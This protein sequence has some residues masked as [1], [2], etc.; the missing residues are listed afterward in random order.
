MFKHLT[1]YCLRT[2]GLICSHFT[3]KYIM[4]LSGIYFFK[5]CFFHVL[6]FIHLKDYEYFSISYENLIGV[7]EPFR[8]RRVCVYTSH[9]QRELIWCFDLQYIGMFTY[10]F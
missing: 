7:L 9:T 5:L 8:L 6:T 10:A 4:M 1:C 3:N 2:Q